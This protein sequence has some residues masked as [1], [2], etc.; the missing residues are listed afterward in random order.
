MIKIYKIIDNTNDN[1]YIGS[2]SQEYLSQRMSRHR[3]NLKN[4]ETCSSKI[5]LKNNDWR[6]EL[7]EVCDANVK[8]EREKYYINNTPNCI[9]A[10][11][12]NFDKKEWNKQPY[13]CECGAIFIR[14]SLYRHRNSDKHNKFLGI[15]ML[16]QVL[17]HTEEQA[18][19]LAKGG[20]LTGEQWES[21]ASKIN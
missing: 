19:I 10:L 11:K 7:V 9:N 17:G 21:H 20:E 8:K 4:H 13:E 5:I 1:V 18:I 3:Q 2:T 12:L 15:K 16:N 14:N 6:Y